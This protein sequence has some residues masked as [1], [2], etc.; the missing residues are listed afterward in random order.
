MNNSDRQKALSAFQRCRVLEEANGEYVRC[1]SC[2]KIVHVSHADGGHYESRK[3]R[4]TELLPENVHAQ[5]VT[6][7]RFLD[8]NHDGYRQGLIER[9]GV[10][11]V[12][13]LET[14]VS[15][16]KG[17]EEAMSRLS[18]EDKEYFKEKDY[19]EVAKECQKKL[20]KLK[21]R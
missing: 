14:I 1:I 6:C 15:A 7:N 10:D 5:C 4:V 2:G 16:S 21:R 8:G 17:C 3:N 20:K 19:K 12:D 9:Y 13:R 18:D 11:Y